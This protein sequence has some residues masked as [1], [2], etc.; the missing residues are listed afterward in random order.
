LTALGFEVEPDEF[1][2]E[3]MT[4]TLSDGSITEDVDG[5]TDAQFFGLRGVYLC[6]QNR[7]MTDPAGKLK[8]L[9]LRCAG[10]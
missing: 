8:K 2:V 1:Q 3:S 5:Y 9:N 7:M 4:V 6:E 10:R